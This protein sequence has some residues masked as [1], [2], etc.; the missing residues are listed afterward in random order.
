MLVAEVNALTLNRCALSQLKRTR[1]KRTLFN[2]CL[3]LNALSL[4]FCVSGDFPNDVTRE[5]RFTSTKVYLIY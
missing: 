2:C 1:S 5:I 3:N 4:N